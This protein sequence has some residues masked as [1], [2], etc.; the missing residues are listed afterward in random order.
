MLPQIANLLYLLFFSNLILKNERTQT[1]TINGYFGIFWQDEFRIWNQSFPTSCIDMLHLRWDQAASHI[2]LPDVA[3]L[4]STTPY[5]LVGSG[6][7]LPQFIGIYSSGLTSIFPGGNMIMMCQFDLTYF[8]FD[9]QVCTIDLEPWEYMID[10]V[11]LKPRR[12]GV[13]FVNTTKHEQWEIVGFDVETKSKSYT[14]NATLYSQLIFNIFLARKSSF[15]L[16]N[17]FLPSYVISWV[18]LVT[19]L[20]PPDIDN[21]LTL[22]FTALLA[23][24]MF[25]SFIASEMPKSSDHQ[26]LLSQYLTIMHLYIFL[27]IAIQGV[28]LYVAK[29]DPRHVPN[30]ISK[31]LNLCENSTSKQQLQVVLII[32]R[33]AITLYFVLIVI[34]PMAA[35]ALF[36]NAS[37]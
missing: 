26:P 10:Q 22:S 35:L 28:T 19:F 18:T 30:F 17:I 8:P 25:N 36:P 37:S 15:Y 31:I 24:S 3:L 16:L 9:R 11:V 12:D 7:Y 13:Y 1:V 6:N 29:A 21:R 14:T 2:W 32:D 27:A 33:I 20:V 23:H 34:T 4:T 5:I